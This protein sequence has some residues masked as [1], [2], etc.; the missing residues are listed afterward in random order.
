[1]ISE[2]FPRTLEIQVDGVFSCRR[3]RW[4]TILPSAINVTI[5]WSVCLS[6]CLSV[7]HVRA[8][9][10]NSRRYWHDF[11]KFGLHWSRKIWLT[12]VN[13]FVP[14]FCHK[15]TH[16]CWF[17]HRSHSMTNCGRMVRDSATITLSSGTIADCLRCPPPQNGGPNAPTRTNF[18]IRAATWQIW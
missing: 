6:V 2:C 5:P 9:C 18:A 15:V 16:P 12:L 13:L 7:C 10:S 4:K 1:M 14:I 11:E 3:Y 8:L 17:D